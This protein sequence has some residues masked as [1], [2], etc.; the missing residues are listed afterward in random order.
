M[1]RCV[2][3]SILPALAALSIL[4]AAPAS[5]QVQR[6]FPPTA[7]RGQLTVLDGPDVKLNG[8]PA[9]LSP[10]A[11]I[12]GVNNMLE[13]SGALQGSTMWVH[14]TLDTQ[15]LLRDVWVLR[16]DELARKPWPATPD[17]AKAWE[18]DAAAQTW[19]KP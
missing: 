10:G 16:P 17:Q 13:M 3:R 2:F 18:F 1:Y 9:R 7:L 4:A 15:G 8:Q 14:Y 5:A 11:R 12:R 19:S 6:Q